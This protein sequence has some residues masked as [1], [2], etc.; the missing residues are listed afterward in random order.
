MSEPEF[1][2]AALDTA[3]AALAD[4]PVVAINGARQVGKSTLARQLWQR[5]GGQVVTLDDETQRDAALADPRGFVERKF[6]GP[7]IIDEVQRVPEL[8][9]AVKAA[10]DRDRRPGRFILTGSTRLLSEPGFADALVGRVEVVELWPLSQGELHDRKDHFVADVFSRTSFSPISLTRAELLRSVLA[11][12]FPEALLRPPTRRSAW[13]DAYLAT[14]TQSVIRDLTGIERLA[15]MPRI[16]RLC[17]A[18]AGTEL[19][20]TNLA[21]ELTLPP[22][23]LDGYLAALAQL[24]I[25][26]LIPAW[27]TNISKKVIRRPKL[28][29]VDSGLAARLVGMTAESAAEPTAPLG[30]LVES[31]VAMELRKQLSWSQDGTTL[32]HFRDRDGAEVDFVLERPDGSI[33]GIEVKAGSSVSS[34]DTKGLRFLADR[35]GDRFVAGVVLSFMPEVTPLGERLTALPLNALWGHP[36]VTGDSKAGGS[37]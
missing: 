24:F 34:R 10:V 37:N 1:R 19:N 13:F 23:T 15:E 26:Q 7:L 16:I 35:L 22:R 36:P 14:L 33:V 21:A 28:V 3:L 12:G 11:G 17:A 20:V 5:A 4:T 30:P 9:R 29:M 2:R 25:V 8:F 6:D 31:F 32:W 18:R 27:S